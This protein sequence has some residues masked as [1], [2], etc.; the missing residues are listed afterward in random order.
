MQDILEPTEV[1][2][3]YIPKNVKHEQALQLQV[4]DYIRQV[5]PN[6]VFR[7]D[8]A[9]GLHLSLYQA[10]L[11][12]RMQS[13]RAWPDLMIFEPK[14]VTLKDGSTQKFCGMAIELK[15]EKTTIIVK[16]G[17]RKGHLTSDPH[18]QE[19]YQLCLWIR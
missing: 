3:R 17:Q 10:K 6:T 19:Q 1:K 9:S 5:K 7:S 15:R 18:I 2:Q 8:Y 16:I 11:H 12:K 4:C 14:E 13:G